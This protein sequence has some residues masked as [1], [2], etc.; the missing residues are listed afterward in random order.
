[1]RIIVTNNEKTPVARL[2]HLFKPTEPQPIEV[3]E[4]EYKVVK[5]VR[6]LTV[7]V[8]PEEPVPKV[9]K[10][11]A[12]APGKNAADKKSGNGKPESGQP[13]K[14]PDADNKDPENKDPEK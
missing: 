14:D 1:M 8:I 3:T 7:E 13:G 6:A 9:V 12:K 4:R 10:V 2:G 11:N 5:A